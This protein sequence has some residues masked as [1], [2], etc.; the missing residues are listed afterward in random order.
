MNDRFLW[1]DITVDEDE[2]RPEMVD[3]FLKR[4]N[5][6]PLIVDVRVCTEDHELDCHSIDSLELILRHLPRIK[7][8]RISCNPIHNDLGVPKML[9]KAFSEYQIPLMESFE[10]SSYHEPWLH[11]GIDP[12][13]SYAPALRKLCL[14]NVIFDWGSP[15]F[16]N[17]TELCINL[18]E[19]DGFIGGEDE[20]MDIDQLFNIF[21]SSPNLTTLLLRFCILEDITILDMKNV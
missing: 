3:A 8:L 17:I 5:P 15:I 13:P 6:T 11:Y 10:L 16:Q 1:A 14:N 18:S 20:W 7:E 12:Q 21:G 9:E 2:A 19:P 4:S